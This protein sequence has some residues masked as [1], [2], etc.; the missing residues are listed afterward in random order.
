MPHFPF[1]VIDASVSVDALRH[2]LPFLFHAIMAVMTY[3]T[4][5]IQRTL[6]EEFQR[7][8]ANRIV[9][10]GHKSLE[11]LQGLLVYV[12]WYHYFHDLKKQQ[13]ATILQL[14]V[15][16]VLDLGLPRDRNSRPERSSEEKRAYLG[17]Y[18]LNSV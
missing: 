11:I 14:C 1:V 17:T 10:L 8:I 7:Q 9:I 5:S 15:A 4:P 3:T 13:L 2:K 6:S 18:Y 12:A 16:Q